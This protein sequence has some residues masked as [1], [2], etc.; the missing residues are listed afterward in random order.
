MP[1][2]VFFILLTAPH[3]AL[4]DC[5]FWTLPRPVQKRSEL[6]SER[7]RGGAN[8]LVKLMLPN[9]QKDPILFA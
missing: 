1:K 8:G 7:E 5:A 6:V 4:R 2:L 3:Q 9:E